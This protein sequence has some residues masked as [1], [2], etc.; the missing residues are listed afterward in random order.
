MHKSIFLTVLLLNCIIYS[1]SREN[2]STIIDSLKNSILIT[3]IDKVEKAKI[4]SEIATEYKTL[5]NYPLAI[6]YQIQALKTFKEINDY[7]KTAEINLFI[8]QCYE[9]I[10]NFESAISY[11]YESFYSAE[12]SKNDSL[13]IDIKYYL[14]VFYS[15][16]NKLEDALV[17]LVQTQQFYNKELGLYQDNLISNLRQLGAVYGRMNK[18]DS[19]LYYFDKA[20]D[21][22][23]IDTVKNNFEIA[24]LYNNIGAIYHKMQD[25]NSAFLKFKKAQRIFSDIN[26]VRGVGISTF[27]LALLFKEQKKFDLSITLFNESA[28]IFRNNNDL[29]SLKECYHNLSNIYEIRNDFDNAFKNFILYSNFKD[30]ITNSNILLKIA[31][32]EAQFQIDK[33]NEE[34]EIK[35]KLLEHEKEL[36]NYRWYFFTGLL[37]IVLMVIILI[38]VRIRSQKK[39]IK[40][41]LKNARLE[42]LN[43]ENERKYLN[44]ELNYKKNELANYANYI[45]QRNEILEKVKT[46]IRILKKSPEKDIS[47]LSRIVNQS[48]TFDKERKEFLVRVEQA[49]KSFF[50]KLQKKFPDITENE[51]RILALVMAELSSKEISSLLNISLGS[52]DMAR[53][54]LRKK[55]N[56]E[57][58]QSIIEFLTNL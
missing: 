3:D 49:N 39:L 53:Y 7:K 26:D 29:N 45:L 15:K 8:G 17:Y 32:A 56:I 41:S 38:L 2:I 36:R 35:I 48:L 31:N 22:A 19:A 11:F 57:S 37:V 4:L 28:A 10:N 5:K 58:N 16:I 12:K 27:N 33:I 23:K 24:G 1:Y 30:S 21:M 54:R 20:L 55:L 50:Y 52:V 18:L 34:N 44:D 42:K 47:K 9:E 14:G 40:V 46:E 6:D 25:Y 43:L 13:I 51:K